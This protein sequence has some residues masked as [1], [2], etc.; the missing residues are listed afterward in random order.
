[1]GSSNSSYCELWESLR[2]GNG[3]HRAVKASELRRDQPLEA[4]ACRTL[5]PAKP[6]A[7]VR[8]LSDLVV[9][10]PFGPFT[11]KA[12]PLSGQRMLMRDKFNTEYFLALHNVVA[13]PG[14]REDGSHYPAFSPNYLGARVKLK[15]VDLK[16]DRWRYHLRG[17]ED[18]EIIQHM[19]FG[20]PLGLQELPNLQ[21]SQRNH[22]S[23]YSFY[24][25]VDKFVTDEVARVGCDGLANDD[26]S[27]KN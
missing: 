1:M 25:H 24:P 5:S 18:V 6:V 20:F 19:E 14:I 13:A 27:K 10:T 2:D 3:Q 21:S 26:S 17:Y 7:N 12:L 4:P 22:G 16:V 11:D 9:Q 23:S 8:H 15:H